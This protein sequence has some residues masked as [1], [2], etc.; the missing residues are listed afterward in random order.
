VEEWNDVRNTVVRNMAGIML[1]Q[2]PRNNER[3]RKDVGRV[4]NVKRES[5]TKAQRRCYVLE[6]KGNPAECTERL[7]DW[8]S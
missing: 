7:S 8:S 5:R 1:H 6:A 3:M 2:E 4:R